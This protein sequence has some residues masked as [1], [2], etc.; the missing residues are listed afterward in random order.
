MPVISCRL[1]MSRK[2][3]LV[4]G[5]QRLDDDPAAGLA[6][7]VLGQLGGA[8]RGE[9]DRFAQ[10]EQCPCGVRP[11]GTQAAGDEDQYVL[12]GS[13]CDG[14]STLRLRSPSVL[15]GSAIVPTH[16]RDVIHDVREHRPAP[17][18]ADHVACMWIQAVSPRSAAFAHRKSPHGSVEIVCEPGSMPRIYGPRTGPVEQALAPGATIVGVRL[19][20][21]AAS[22][23]LGMPARPSST[24]P[25]TPTSSGAIEADALQRARRRGDIRQGGGSAP[26]AGRGRATRRR[27]GPGPVVARA[28]QRLMSGRRADVAAMAS[29]LFI[30]ERQLRRRFE[31]ATGLTPTT[32]HRILRFQRFLALAWTRTRPSTQ[33][34]ASPSKPAT[35]I[36]R[37]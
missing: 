18:L 31:A 29:S 3:R 19:R 37:T 6:G 14:P 2:A 33:V 21:E 20:P 28:V 16:P 5:V 23:V 4:R 1:P 32:L 27:S 12:S 8:V 30:S 22:A 24:S 25:S 7:E 26:G 17:P 10:V 34:A 15:N 35:P 9:H 11:D 13:S 36:T